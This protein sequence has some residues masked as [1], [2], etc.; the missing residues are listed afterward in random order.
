MRNL[1]PI[2]LILAVPL[3]VAGFISAPP[4]EAAP[5]M[6]AA[7]GSSS[8]DGKAIFLREKC[9][10]CHV[11]SSAGIESKAK[12]EKLKAADLTGVGKRHET[13]VLRSYIKKETELDGEKH[14]KTFKGTDAELDVLIAWLESQ[15]K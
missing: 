3:A 14:K 8:L 11:V 1:L 5:G 4:A 15:K 2:L 9:E 13:A 12:S 6:A 7:G 10:T